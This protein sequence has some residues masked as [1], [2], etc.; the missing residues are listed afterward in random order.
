M[1]RCD[2]SRDAEHNF[3]FSADEHNFDASA[4]IVL[5]ELA[6]DLKLCSAALCSDN[7]C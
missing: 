5:G 4:E 7:M 3:R 2:P 1:Q 6:L